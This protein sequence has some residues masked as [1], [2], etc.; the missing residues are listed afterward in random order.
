MAVQNQ[1]GLG[2]S[3]LSTKYATDFAWK[4]ES[5]ANKE[6]GLY[7]IVVD[8]EKRILSAEYA[9]RAKYHMENFVNRLIADNTIGKL[10]RITVDDQ[11]VRTIQDD[12]T[13]LMEDA[14]N[15]YINNGTQYIKGV[16]FNID[17]DLISKNNSSRMYNGQVRARIAM[18]VSV[19]PS[20][21]RQVIEDSVEYI[22]ST[23]WALDYHALE[24]AVGDVVLTVD[25]ITILPDPSFDYDNNVIALYDILMCVIPMRAD[26]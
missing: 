9:A 12:R 22:N 17:M 20:S 1:Y 25:D 5:V 10:W 26:E 18:T 24:G 4:Y 8:D 16:R 2:Y 19:G 3:P 6:V 13:N 7:G 14:E 15:C 21:I 11:M 23:A